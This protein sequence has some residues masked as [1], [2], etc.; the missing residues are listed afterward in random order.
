MNKI[1]PNMIKNICSVPNVTK[2]F[3][4]YEDNT[5]YFSEGTK[6]EYLV[7]IKKYIYEVMTS[8]L[9]AGSFIMDT[10]FIDCSIKLFSNYFIDDSNILNEKLFHYFK[11]YKN[12]VNMCVERKI[13]PC[14]FRNKDL[15]NQALE[16]ANNQLNQIDKFFKDS[17]YEERM[18]N[19]FS[20]FDK[21]LPYENL[22][23]RS[24]K[25]LNGLIE[26]SGIMVPNKYVHLFISNVIRNNISA[27]FLAIRNSLESIVGNYALNHNLNVYFEATTTEF[28]TKG[29]YFD[30]VIRI[31]D[32]LI[33]EF[34]KNPQAN[35]YELFN[36]LFFELRELIQDKGFKSKRKMNYSEIKML[37][38]DLL[39]MCLKS[40]INIKRNVDVGKDVDEYQIASIY[41]NRYLESIGLK[42]FIKKHRR[43]KVNDKS[44]VLVDY[45]MVKVD[46]LFDEL[47]P[48]IIKQYS[49]EYEKDIFKEYPIL[50]L[51]YDERGR[52]YS[53]LELFKLREELKKKKS[54][55]SEIDVHNINQILFN[56]NLSFVNLV[57]DY[58][59]MVMDSELEF[60]GKDDY[61]KNYLYSKINSQ[62][63]RDFT[64]LSL[65]LAQLRKKD[66]KEV[67][68]GVKSTIASGNEMTKIFSDWPNNQVD[69][70]ELKRLLKNKKT[71]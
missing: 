48:N 11:N 32:D 3:I 57:A 34:I 36:E 29:I 4:K 70:V 41:T 5:S 9:Y 71:A 13:G 18:L 33:L 24:F 15:R 56:Q 20:Y 42:D 22:S 66:I 67:M 68:E 6:E 64:N 17:N 38:N 1:S 51:M 7:E 53:T 44:D 39:G 45:K 8:Y 58:K 62:S 31:K 10:H 40:S 26:S 59:E 30:N 52:R 43:K 54:I 16:V 25:K 35:I 27:S 37:K 61:I 19:A 49:T 47:F 63:T 2:M 50:S 23:N 60:D 69:E 46:Q 65:F 21:Y 28:D 14:S 55:S 12:L